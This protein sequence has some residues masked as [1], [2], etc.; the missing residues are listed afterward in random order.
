MICKKDQH[1]ENT[2]SSEKFPFVQRYKDDT[3]KKHVVIFLQIT[4]CFLCTISA[5]DT[6]RFV[7]LF[8]LNPCLPT[9]PLVCYQHTK[10]NIDNYGRSLIPCI[11][12]CFPNICC[13]SEKCVT[14]FTASVLSDGDQRSEEVWKTYLRK[15][16]RM[17][18]RNPH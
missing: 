2:L 6:R 14:G 16:S 5:D 4:T 9:H 11:N 18:Q 3:L 17:I 15:A 7:A 1:L 13:I 12:E 10:R 8:T